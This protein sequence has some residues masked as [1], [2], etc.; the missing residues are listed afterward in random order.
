MNKVNKIIYLLSANT[1]DSPYPV[2]PIGISYIAAYLKANLQDYDVRVFDLNRVSLADFCA[3]VT[4][5]PPGV[6]GISL[7]NID[8]VNSCHEEV[9]IDAYRKIIKQIRGCSSCPVVIGGAGYSI[10]PVRLFKELNPDFGIVG[11]GERSFAELITALSDNGDYK[12]INGLV[13]AG[14]GGEIRVNPRSQYIREADLMYDQEMLDFYWS[15]SGMINLQTKRGCH[16][17]CIYCTYPLIEGKRVRTLDPEKVVNNLRFLAKTKG[18]NYVYF[19]DSLFN[20]DR[21]YNRELAE[22]I[23]KEKIDIQWG[24]FFSPT[25][26]LDYEELEL[27]KKSGLSHIE[28]GT[29]SL[30]DEVLKAYRKQFTFSDVCEVSKICSGL[31]INTAHFLILGGPGE[32]QD[33]L[34]D[35]VRKSSLID[36]TVF[37]PF[38]GMRIYP[39][40]PLQEYAIA[41]G[42]IGKDDDL[43]QP[44]FYISKGLDFSVLENGRDSAGGSVWVMPG[45]N[46]SEL[47]GRLRKK[48]YKGPLWDLLIRWS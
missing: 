47:L 26:D 35:T 18:V 44:V 46:Y 36:N 28:F 7:R 10:F 31:R 12:H 11:E 9:F 23:I 21:E 24:A 15:K 27:Y 38:I 41:E 40:T 48:N 42:V 14:E 8:N 43:L 20:I 17:G 25:R 30:N 32:T 3:A 19:T 39:C 45:D 22:R 1:T 2:Y 29:E 37:F 6:I 4:S 33:T 13:Y 34:L 16:S 5:E